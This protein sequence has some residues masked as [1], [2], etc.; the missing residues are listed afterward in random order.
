[1]LSELFS[2]VNDGERAMLISRGWVFYATEVQSF[3]M[4]GRQIHLGGLVV[5]TYD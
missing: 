5:H 1:M 4:P 3:H 2:E